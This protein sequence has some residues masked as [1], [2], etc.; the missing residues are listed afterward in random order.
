MV[1]V[2]VCQHRACLLHPAAVAPGQLRDRGG[3]E[4]PQKFTVQPLPAALSGAQAGPSERRLLWEANP[5]RVHGPADSAA[6]HQV[7][8]WERLAAPD[9]PACPPPSLIQTPSFQ[10]MRGT[11][12]STPP[13]VHGSRCTWT[14]S[15]WA[16]ARPPPV[17]RASGHSPPGDRTQDSPQLSLF[18]GNF[19]G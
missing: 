13:D 6:G 12:L 1:P 2:G 15:E 18:I 16:A 14:W 19:S 4:S 11:L 8:P 5:L 3:R 10:R 17:G 7:G 9:L